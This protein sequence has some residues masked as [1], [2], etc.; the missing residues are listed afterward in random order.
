MKAAEKGHRDVADALINLNAE[1]NLQN[2]VRT[3]FLCTHSK[4]YFQLITQ[5]DFSPICL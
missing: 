5:H 1:L 3:T 4:S 2:S